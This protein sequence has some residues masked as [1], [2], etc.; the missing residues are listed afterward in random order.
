M[1]A[2]K[3]ITVPFEAID[4]KLTADDDRDFWQMALAV[5]TDEFVQRH[6]QESPQQDWA[7]VVGACSHWERPHQTRWTAGGGF[8]APKGY[9]QHFPTLD[10]TVVLIYQN[11][12]L[13]PAAK[14]PG[15][16]VKLFQIAIPSRTRRHLRSEE[17]TS[18]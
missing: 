7:I 12:E 5:L 15:K 11:G 9:K 16:R 10:W 14:L 1:K 3:Q 4:A 18:D 6:E 2:A 13:L 17:H 8:A